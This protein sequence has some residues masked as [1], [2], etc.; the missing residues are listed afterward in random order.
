MEKKLELQ[1]ETINNVKKA[2]SGLHCRGK[3]TMQVLQMDIII[4]CTSTQVLYTKLVEKYKISYILTHKLNQDSL[5]NLFSQLR[6]RGGLHDHCWGVEPPP[7][8]QKENHPCVG[9]RDI[10]TTV[11]RVEQSQVIYKVDQNSLAGDEVD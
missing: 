10:E 3:N 4:S 6:T 8:L 11:P 9:E 5:E 2:F 7:S 1:I